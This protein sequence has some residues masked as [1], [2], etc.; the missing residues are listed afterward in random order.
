MTNKC[1]VQAKGYIW[2]PIWWTG[3][4]VLLNSSHFAI[5]A[6]IDWSTKAIITPISYQFVL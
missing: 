3:P 2:A 5:N 6:Y 1:V 4:I